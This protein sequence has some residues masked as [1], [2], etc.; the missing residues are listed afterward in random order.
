[1]CWLSYLHLSLE[2]RYLAIH[3]H[4]CVF[5][6]AP[7]I[8]IHTRA[9][10]CVHLEFDA[11]A[12]GAGGARHVRNVKYNSTL[13]RKH[14]HIKPLHALH[15]HSRAVQGELDR[16]WCWNTQNKNSNQTKVTKPPTRPGVHE[17]FFHSTH[18]QFVASFS[19]SHL[20]IRNP[21]TRSKL[22][23]TVFLSQD[24]GY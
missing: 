3:T 20:S 6:C 5:V 4:A 12:G 15:A 24:T 18:F 17:R 2:Y 22:F 10:S 8:H 23:S 19:D 16:H 1:M 11:R 7:F 21:T 14:T 13:K 9:C